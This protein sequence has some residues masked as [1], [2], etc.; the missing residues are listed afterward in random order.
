MRDRSIL[1]CDTQ[2]ET[3]RMTIQVPT[4]MEDDDVAHLDELV[5]AGVGATR[6]QVIRAAVAELYD[7]HRR[8]GIGAASD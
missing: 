2:Y 5:E 6:S 1:M 8:A 3:V 4:R 7:R